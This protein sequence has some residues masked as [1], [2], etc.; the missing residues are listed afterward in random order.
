M[1]GTVARKADFGVNL[2][3]GSVSLSLSTHNLSLV[4]YQHCGQS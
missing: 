1:G 4:L 3:V 2:H